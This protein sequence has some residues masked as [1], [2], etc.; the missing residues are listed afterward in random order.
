[1][2]AQ[3][4]HH[5][6]QLRERRQHSMRIWKEMVFNPRAY[7]PPQEIGCVQ[8]WRLLAAM[9]RPSLEWLDAHCQRPAAVSLPTLV[10]C[11]NSRSVWL[12]MRRSA[13]PVRDGCIHPR[14]PKGCADAQPR[15]PVGF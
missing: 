8:R 9:L 15:L 5:Q 11:G 4:K 6:D 1:M 13:T 14:R 3:L 12:G 10:K 2:H 7:L